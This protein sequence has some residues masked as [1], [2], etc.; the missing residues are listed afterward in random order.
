MTRSPIEHLTP[1]DLEAIG[2]ELD[3]IRDEVMADVGEQDANYIRN[4]IKTQRTLEA[5][6]G[7][8]SNVVDWR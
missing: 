5:G 1:D 7:E 8:L 4:V 3:A 6:G 2:A